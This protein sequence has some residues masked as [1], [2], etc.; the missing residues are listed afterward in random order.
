MIRLI[1]GA[2]GSHFSQRKREAGT[3]LCSSSL[4]FFSKVPEVIDPVMGSFQLGRI[5]RQLRII[6]AANISIRDLFPLT[7]PSVGRIQTGDV[8]RQT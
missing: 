6:E 2:V 1:D 7:Y 8:G 5:K 4:Y 3:R